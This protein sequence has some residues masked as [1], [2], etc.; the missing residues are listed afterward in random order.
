MRF[1]YA[2]TRPL[3]DEEITRIENLVNDEVLANL[4]VETEVTTQGEAR[5]RG[6]MMI[7]EENYLGN[8]ILPMRESQLQK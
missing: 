7:F 1:D 2:S 4:P 8:F 3:T 5:A 6:A